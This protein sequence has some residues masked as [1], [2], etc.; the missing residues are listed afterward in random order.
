[1]ANNDTSTLTLADA[2]KANGPS[3]P[4]RGFPIASDVSVL[5]TSTS[6]NRKPLQ[7][8]AENDWFMREVRD[9]LRDGFVVSKTKFKLDRFNF[10][11]DSYTLSSTSERV[12]S[13]KRVYIED[14]TV[15]A[16]KIATGRA[17]TLTT[18]IERDD[19]TTMDLEL[20]NYIPNAGGLCW[21]LKEV[22]ADFEKA[23]DLRT[24]ANTLPNGKVCVERFQAGE[25]LTVGDMVF[26]IKRLDGKGRLLH[27]K[28]DARIRFL[29]RRRQTLQEC[30]VE[31]SYRERDARGMTWTISY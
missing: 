7:D 13:N 10:V 9:H 31:C 14:E 16:A 19:V 27:L 21:S 1:M 28:P 15:L 26:K 24:Q 3:T 22:V 25:L 29:C 23:L 5:F 17:R 2:A 11:V 4:E 12:G 30:S 20:L 6:S 18:Y 8:L